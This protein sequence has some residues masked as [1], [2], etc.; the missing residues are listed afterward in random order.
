MSLAVETIVTCETPEQCSHLDDIESKPKKRRTRGKDQGHSP[1]YTEFPA[2]VISTQ[3]CQSSR[4][5]H[6]NRS[7]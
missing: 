2:W 5:I 7:P 6:F 3:L 1:L 4:L